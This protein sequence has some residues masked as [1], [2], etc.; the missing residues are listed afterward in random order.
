MRGPGQ[1]TSSAVM[2][3]RVEPHDS[4]DDFPTQ[5]WAGRALCE[6]V[7]PGLTQGCDLLEPTINRGYLAH[8]LAD[9][10]QLVNG[11]DIFDYG[12]GAP[13]ID[14]LFPG[15]IA[16]HDWV[17][18]N[19]P[20]RLAE[21]FIVRAFDVATK[22]VAVFVRAGFLEGVGRY[23][24]LYAIGPPTIVAHFAE[25]VPLVK[26]RVDP[27][28]ST[29]TA[30][31]W[32][33]WIKGEAARPPVWIPPCRKALERAGDYDGPHRLRTAGRGV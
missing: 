2:A 18:F 1:N 10:F 14:F 13:V 23:E 4:L 26:G 33:V 12:I 19:P 7:L 25:R 20:F 28:A 5:P 11:S 31:V 16:R 29:A 15:D 21:Q 22:G 9:Y 6:H 27:D 24:R 8:G 32:L 30:Y 3:Q 17:A